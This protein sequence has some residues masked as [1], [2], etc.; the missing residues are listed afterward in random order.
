MNQKLPTPTKAKS[1]SPERTRKTMMQTIKRPTTPTREY[2]SAKTM[3][4]RTED[5]NTLLQ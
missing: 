4:K 2:V 5:L 3:T 1:K